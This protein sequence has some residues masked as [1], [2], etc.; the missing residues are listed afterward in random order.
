[1]KRAQVSFIQLPGKK[2]YLTWMWVFVSRKVILYIWDPSRGSSVPLAHLGHLAK[3]FLTVDRYSAYKKLVRLVPGLTIAFCWV[4]FRR[5]FIRA[6]LADKTLRPWAERWQESIGEIFRLNKV[7]K[8]DPARQ[9]DLE[10][11][12]EKMEKTINAELEETT[13]SERQHKVL[14]SAKK[15]WEGLTVFV[16]HPEVPMDN[17]SAEQQLRTV[18]LGRNN[19]YGSRAEWSSHL[20]A[21]CLSLIKTA[22]LNGLNPQ[23]YL[24]YYLDGCGKAGGVPEDL[25]PYLPWNLT[26]EKLREGKPC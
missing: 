26:P 5:D 18:A 4:H 25:T 16:D 22:Q 20:A 9:K 8:K 12:L 19:Y 23:E 2:N 15:H 21:V 10:K 7:R 6:A 24:R 13:L 14:K 3:G 11:A 17:N 1:M